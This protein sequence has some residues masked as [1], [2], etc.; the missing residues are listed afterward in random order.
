M[1]KDYAGIAPTSFSQEVCSG[2][3]S[4]LPLSKACFEIL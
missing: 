3:G 2:H 4:V 1:V